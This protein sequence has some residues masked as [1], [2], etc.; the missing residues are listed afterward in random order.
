[1]N[2]S[3]ASLLIDK[4]NKTALGFGAIVQQAEAPSDVSDSD[5]LNKRK[6]S[7]ASF[8]QKC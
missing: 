3:I 4:L 5:A 6:D 7:L 2:P 1:M 8:S